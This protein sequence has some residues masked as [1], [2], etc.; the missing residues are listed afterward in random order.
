MWLIWCLSSSRGQRRRRMRVEGEEAAGWSAVRLDSFEPVEGA[1]LLICADDATGE[2]AWRD[3]T[4]T[5]CR[6]DLGP[7]AIRLVRRR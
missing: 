5:A 2:V 7:H 3:V 1:G 4:N 6:A